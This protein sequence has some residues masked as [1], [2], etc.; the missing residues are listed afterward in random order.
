MVVEGGVAPFAPA[1]MVMVQHGGIESE[2]AGDF[3]VAFA[4][5][6]LTCERIIGALE[7]HGRAGGSAAAAGSGA[8]GVRR[9]VIGVHEALPR[10]GG[11]LCGL[12]CGG[13]DPDD[14]VGH[15]VAGAGGVGVFVEGF[16][17][18]TVITGGLFVDLPDDRCQ[19]VGLVGVVPDAVGGDED[20]SAALEGELGGV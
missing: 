16:R 8:A 3:Q 15:V 19:R 4:G 17:D 5:A 13:V 10:V 1:G 11:G 7:G 2:R 18:R 14:E 12:S 20:V 6:P 9:L